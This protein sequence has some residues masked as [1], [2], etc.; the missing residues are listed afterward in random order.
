[1]KTRPLLARLRREPRRPRAE[2]CTHEHFLSNQWHPIGN[3]EERTREC[4]VAALCARI[5]ERGSA[6]RH[7]AL[8]RVVCGVEL[9]NAVLGNV[10]Q[11]RPEGL[12]R[13]RLVAE[14]AQRLAP[15]RAPQPLLRR[16]VE[17]PREVAARLLHA[18]QL[19]GTQKGEHLLRD[20]AVEHLEVS[21]VA[22]RLLDTHHGLPLHHKARFRRRAT[23][24]VVCQR[25]E[26]CLSQCRQLQSTRKK[27]VEL[28][29]RR[30]H[31]SLVHDRAGGLCALHLHLRPRAPALS[32]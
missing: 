24:D 30:L 26:V 1:M 19:T 20:V 12:G 3:R 27:V 29:R 14:G 15:G 2:E 18:R 5:E 21:R 32:R 25:V 17:H 23:R 8:H 16:A 7:E 9:L 13:A 31:F 6:S 22:L 10:R 11:Y 4:A 28:R